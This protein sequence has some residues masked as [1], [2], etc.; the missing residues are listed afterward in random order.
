MTYFKEQ[1]NSNKSN[2]YNDYPLH[3]EMLGAK[4]VQQR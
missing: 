3:S 2:N 4:Y 1:V